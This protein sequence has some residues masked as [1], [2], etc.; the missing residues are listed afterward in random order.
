MSAPHTPGRKQESGPRSYVKAAVCP[1]KDDARIQQFMGMVRDYRDH[2]SVLWN[3]P[4]GCYE[5]RSNNIGEAFWRGWYGE[6]FIW[7]KAAP[8][9]VAYKAGAAIAKATGAA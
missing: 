5:N 2:R 3:G 7:D 6:R 1:F 9:Y 8:L 4:G